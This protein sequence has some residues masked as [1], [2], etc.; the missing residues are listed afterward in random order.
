[1]RRSTASCILL[2]LALAARVPHSKAQ[3][4]QLP[5]VDE[6]EDLADLK[7][8]GLS[9]DAVPSDDLGGSGFDLISRLRE[10][11]F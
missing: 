5:D 8:T 11:G 10:V 1:M 4:G 3:R 6:E 7:A 9:E 2:L